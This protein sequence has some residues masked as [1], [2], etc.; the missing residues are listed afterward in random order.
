MIPISI[1]VSG[2]VQALTLKAEQAEALAASVLDRVV[3]SFANDWRALAGRKL[4]QTRSE[5][6]NAIYVQQEG[7]RAAVVGLKGWL[8]NAV[9]KGIDPFDEKEGFAASQKKKLKKNGG[10]YVTVPFRFATPYAVADSSIFSQTMPTAVYE[11]AKSL[12]AG[13]A[14]KTKNLAPQLQNLGVRKEVYS[15]QREQVYHSYQHKSSI[16]DGM[17]RKER[18]GGGS[19]YVTF[20]RVSD[21]SDQNSWI[22]SGIRARNLAAETLQSFPIA[23][24]VAQ[25]KLEFYQKNS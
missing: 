5:Y 6:M 16:Y 8:P 23:D 4:K 14:L 22:H 3:T 19:M 12:P 9:E 18:N 10:W 17:Q 24:V 21:T 20:R 13:T 1:D 11:V 7:P 15:A 25:V 2:V